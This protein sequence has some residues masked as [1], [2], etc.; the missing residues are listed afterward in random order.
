MALQLWRRWQGVHLLPFHLHLRWPDEVR[1]LSLIASISMAPFFASNA[2]EVGSRFIYRA[3]DARER[4]RSARWARYTE[5]RVLEYDL[6]HTDWEDCLR[7][8]PELQDLVLPPASYVAVD[9]VGRK[10][11]VRRGSRSRLGRHCAR[12]EPRP[13][14]IVP[15]KR[16]IANGAVGALADTELL[17]VN[18]QGLR[19]RNTLAGLRDLVAVRGANRPTLLVA[20]NPGE[21]LALGWEGVRQFP[22]FVEGSLP[23]P[24]EV[25]VSTVGADR[26]LAE[27]MYEFAIEDLDTL[28][29]EAG[30]VIVL[31]KAAWWALRQSFGVEF[32]DLPEGNRF[33]SALDELRS[34]S[35]REAEHLKGIEEVLLRYAAD[36][37]LADERKRA[38][39]STTLEAGG[40]AEVLVLTRDPL[41][42][43]RMRDEIAGDLGVS[44]PELEKLGVSIKTPFSPPPVN[45]PSAVVLTGYS[46]RA[47]LDA[48]LASRAG[49]VR[50]VLDPIE[51]RAAWYGLRE[52]TLYLEATGARDAARALEPLL[53]EIG[54]HVPPGGNTIA[55]G[56]DEEI[57][58]PGVRSVIRGIRRAPSDEALVSFTDGSVLTLGVNARLDVLP[59]GGSRFRSTSVAEVQS[60]DR[61]VLLDEDDRR[62]F[63]TRLMEVLDATTLRHEA[64]ERRLW[65]T[66]VRAIVSE[67]RP[68]MRE[69]QRRLNARGETV[70]YATVRAWCRPW[71]DT[72]IAIPR[73]RSCFMAFAELLG[74][75]LPESRLEEMFQA[76][77]RW[78]TL[79]RRDGRKLAR[80]MRAAYMNRLDAVTL[81]KVEREWG[82]EVRR[83]LEAARVGVVDEI[84]LPGGHSDVAD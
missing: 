77:R 65:S 45:P 42:A 1:N 50:L 39:L 27:R 57:W 33:L 24:H 3:G 70:T 13:S 66:L 83:L 80:V 28:S 84:I 7:R 44:R 38:I 17:I 25:L 14:V 76:V 69:I 73:S 22:H 74:V 37:A 19:G 8:R 11:S 20:S 52:S 67:N 40:T 5:K 32:Q 62:S 26:P 12:G 63:S 18:L 21:L 49:S 82:F 35:P 47:S 72:G 9:R 56:W 15:G 2:E 48:V 60:G 23:R 59:E 30:Q 79:H 29:P 75:G 55:V 6:F 78:R 51:A 53:E 61:V 58:N 81:A 46:G 54:K 16:G 71:E 34:S 31:G 43:R 64:E 4:R 10:G 68:N 36:G 41:T